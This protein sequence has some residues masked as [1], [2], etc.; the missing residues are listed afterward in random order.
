MHDCKSKELKRNLQYAIFSLIHIF[1]GYHPLVVRC[2]HPRKCNYGTMCNLSLDRGTLHIIPCPT[3]TLEGYEVSI[4]IYHKLYPLRSMCC[5]MYFCYNVVL[6]IFR[7]A[8][9]FLKLL[10]VVYWFQKRNITV[11]KFEPC[12][13]DH[14][15]TIG[16]IPFHYKI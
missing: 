3:Y 8:Y 5:N 7:G 16:N 12:H 13:G 2:L 9:R 11:A 14:Y 15:D 1:H 10:L 4:L 6:Y